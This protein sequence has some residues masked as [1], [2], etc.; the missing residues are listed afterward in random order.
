MRYSL[1][2]IAYNVYLILYVSYIYT[3]AFGLTSN[4]TAFDDILSVTENLYIPFFVKPSIVHFI[5][6]ALIMHEFFNVGAIVHVLLFSTSIVYDL[7]TGLLPG[8]VSV[9]LYLL[10]N[11]LVNVNIALSLPDATVTT[12][13]GVDLDAG[14]GADAGA[15]AD[16]GGKLDAGAD[17][18]AGAGAGADVGA[19]AGV[20]LDVGG[21][22]DAG[23]DLGAGADVALDVG[24]KLDAGVALDVGGKLDAGDDLDA[25]AGVGAGVT[26]NVTGE[27][28]EPLLYLETIE[29]VY[30]LLVKSVIVHTVFELPI[31]QFLSLPLISQFFFLFFKSV[32]V[33]FLLLDVSVII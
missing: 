8:D 32:I 15:S 5:F 31:S 18:G 12:G 26:I 33:Y 1:I 6:E 27:D 11:G 24:G 29:N 20:A 30:S 22:L 17:V 23:D 10:A 14:A 19:G 21:K 28:I 16:V 13:A 3:Y 25:G 2:S 4:V 9:I 7:L